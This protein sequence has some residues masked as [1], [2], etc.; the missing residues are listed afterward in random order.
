M[1]AGL[2]AAEARR[3]VQACLLAPGTGLFERDDELGGLLCLQ[4]E[5]YREHGRTYTDA[6]RAELAAE[7]AAERKLVIM[8]AQLGTVTLDGEGSGQ[9]GR[10]RTWRIAPHAKG[11]AS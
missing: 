2:I 7:E 11:G 3:Y 6:G 5:R 4:V 1:N 8:V 10:I 9:Y